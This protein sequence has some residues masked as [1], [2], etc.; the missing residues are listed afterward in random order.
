MKVA[1]IIP[2]I[3]IPVRIPGLYFVKTLSAL[4][5]VRFNPALFIYFSFLKYK[6]ESTL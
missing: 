2:A 4:F 6:R 3:P 5:I 1:P